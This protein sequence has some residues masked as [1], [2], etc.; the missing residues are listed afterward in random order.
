[1]RRRPP[2]PGR[3]PRPSARAASVLLR[4]W[5]PHK[6]MPPSSST[7]EL[8]SSRHPEAPRPGHAPN[9][10]PE[11]RRRQELP[12]PPPVPRWRAASDHLRPNRSLPEVACDFLLLSHPGSPATGNYT[13]RILAGAA[14]LLQVRPGTALQGPKSFQGPLCNV[15]FFSK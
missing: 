6:S 15:S 3:P 2:P 11:R 12:P 8:A 13:R 7:P 1:M 10:S 9:P 5:R 14:P 4:P